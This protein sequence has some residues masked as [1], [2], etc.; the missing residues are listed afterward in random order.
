MK[1][2]HSL[3]PESTGQDVDD[4]LREDGLAAEVKARAIKKGMVALLQGAGLTQVELATRLC[5][6]HSRVA[7]PGAQPAANS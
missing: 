1:N 2:T 4:F 3:K 6:A 7:L 5:C